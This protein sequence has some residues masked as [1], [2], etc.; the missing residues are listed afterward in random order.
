MRRTKEEA[1][2]TRKQLL[3]AA[4][5]IFRT[6]GYAATTLE[7]IARKAG[8]TRGAIQ[9][10]FGGKADLYNA[11]IRECYQE[12]G[13]AFQDMYRPEGTALQKLRMGLVRWLSYT[14]ENMKFRTMLEMM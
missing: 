3:E 5:R 13:E 11:L 9:W 4:L 7:E 12:A 8:I 2:E 6:R 1:A 10:H 14:E